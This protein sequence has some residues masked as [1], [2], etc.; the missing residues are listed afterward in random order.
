M[1]EAVGTVL[2]ARVL[3]GESWS[4]ARCVNT[5]V[6][7]T[8]EGV[9]VTYDRLAG[10]ADVTVPGCATSA[11][12]RHD[13]RLAACSLQVRMIANDTSG[14]V[15][16]PLVD[17]PPEF[18]GLG[19]R[20][21][22]RLAGQLGVVPVGWPPTRYH[23]GVRLPPASRWCEA[24]DDDGHGLCSGTRRSRGL[25]ALHSAHIERT[26]D[27]WELQ[28]QRPA[29]YVC[30]LHRWVSAYAIRG[31]PDLHDEYQMRPRSGVLDDA[32]SH[33]RRHSGGGCGGQLPR[34]CGC[35]RSPDHYAVVPCGTKLC[36][37]TRRVVERDA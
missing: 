10:V 18:Y 33:L 3:D 11:R 35:S 12:R 22:R 26:L 15:S 36:R 30:S 25:A 13:S 28:V 29:T 31:K 21:H 8:G 19:G 5:T 16:A 37:T 14:S 34:R 23:P 20:G 9:V 4:Y 24:T 6:E 7:E 32:V 27:W 17:R 1:I 2:T